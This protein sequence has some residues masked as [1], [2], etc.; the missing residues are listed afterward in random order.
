MTLQ[1]ICGAY[2]YVLMNFLCMSAG[3]QKCP[4]REQKCYA[5]TRLQQLHSE[6]KRRS[7]I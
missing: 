5:E 2:P 4:R 3:K 6:G 1:T 7:L